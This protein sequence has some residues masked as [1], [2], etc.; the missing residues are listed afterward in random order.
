V[1]TRAGRRSLGAIRWPANFQPPQWKLASWWWSPLNWRLDPGSSSSAASPAAA[2][3]PGCTRSFRRRG[4]SCPSPI[5]A[6]ELAR[7]GHQ[8]LPVLHL[9]FQNRAELE[10]FRDLASPGVELRLA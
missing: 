1:N 6:V 2:P 7:K 4:T 10:R 3:R 8:E 5:A 9:S